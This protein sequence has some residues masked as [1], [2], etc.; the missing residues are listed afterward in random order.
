MVINAQSRWVVRLV[1]LAFW[2][3]AA[4]SLAWWGLRLGGRAAPAPSANQTAVTTPVAVADPS[5]VA[6]LL[7]AAAPVG[8][9]AAPAAINRFVLLGVVASPS[10][11]GSA[12]I[13]VDGKPGRAFRVGSKVDEGLVLEAVE[14]RK[15]RLT[16]PGSAAEP[17]VLEMPLP[18][19]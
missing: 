13:A 18:K 7:G 4:A 6:K 17:M 12:L 3:M 5:A 8:P 19:R 1:T 10:H 9:A 14:P 2:A 15:A 11:R 16:Q